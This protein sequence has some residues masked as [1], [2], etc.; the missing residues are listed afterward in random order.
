M[1]RCLESEKE[2]MMTDIGGRYF[3]DGRR[4]KSQ[5]IRAASRSYTAKKMD[6][7]LETPARN[8]ALLITF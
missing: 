4:A 1:A 8:T 7:S 6:A 3:T 2:E 5:E